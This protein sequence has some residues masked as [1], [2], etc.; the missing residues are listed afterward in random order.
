MHHGVLTSD[1]DLIVHNIQQQFYHNNFQY[2]FQLMYTNVLN[3]QQLVWC[4]MTC[5]WYIYV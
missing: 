2:N 4:H 3:S 1:F 5:M